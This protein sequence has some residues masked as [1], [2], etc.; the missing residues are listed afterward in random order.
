MAEQINPVINRKGVGK[1]FFAT[2]FV[3]REMRGRLK[4][5][6]KRHTFFAVQCISKSNEDIEI[7]DY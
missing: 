3:Q 2:N 1:S 4:N 5:Y 7:T 6:E